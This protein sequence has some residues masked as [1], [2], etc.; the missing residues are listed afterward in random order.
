MPV[1]I[2]IAV[3]FASGATSSF[4]KWQQE[5]RAWELTVSQALDFFGA[6]IRI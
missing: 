1:S 2:E 3:T 6:D 4:T 5:K